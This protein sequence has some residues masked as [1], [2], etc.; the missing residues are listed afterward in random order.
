MIPIFEGG[1]FEFLQG[2]FGLMGD[3]SPTETLLVT[4]KFVHWFAL[5]PGRWVEEWLRAASKYNKSNKRNM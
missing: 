4:V 1:V 2:G 5:I 3:V